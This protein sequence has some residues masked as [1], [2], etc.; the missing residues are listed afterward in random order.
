MAAK[1]EARPGDIIIE[2]IKLGKYDIRFITRDFSVYESIY[3]N[4]MYGEIVVNDG[5]SIFDELPIVG[6]EK[7]EITFKD[8]N[9][10]DSIDVKFHI[11]R[12]YPMVLD[13]DQIVAYKMDLVS[14]YKFNDI[15]RIIQKSYGPKKISEIVQ[16]VAKTI[17]ISDIEVDPTD[18]EFKCV[19]PS[20][21]PFETIEYLASEA[22]S[23]KYDPSDYFFFENRKKHFFTTISKLIADKKKSDKFYFSQQSQGKLEK[24]WKM[25]TQFEFQF[26]D[27]IVNTREGLYDGTT[28]VIDPLMQT[29]R[30]I[31]PLDN[32]KKCFR[33]KDDFDKFQ[34]IASNKIISDGAPE[35]KYAGTSHIRYMLEN[36][37]QAD[38]KEMG[39]KARKR[40]E[41]VLLMSSAQRQLKHITCEF[42]VPGNSKLN[43]GDFITLEIPKFC[44][45]EGKIGEKSKLYAGDWMIT[46]L[47][48]SYTNRSANPYVTRITAV[49]N[50]VESS[51]QKSGG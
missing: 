48:N 2:K 17:D 1:S 31:G 46:D 45:K 3:S 43:I 12:L 22:K 20:L 28:L 27:K 50:T 33:Y 15:T 10:G 37:T 47:R 41:V 30:R 26:F 14:K 16:E 29:Y 9:N 19:I 35:A 23:E 32:S 42:N 7:I 38:Q 25:V 21:S 51:I 11:A 40:P 5:L 8:A 24:E 36:K 49:K 39:V 34:K 44:A 18:G 4:Y 13:H 6:E